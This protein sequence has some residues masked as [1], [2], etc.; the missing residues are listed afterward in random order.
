MGG[1][2]V[3]R[4][5]G[6]KRIDPAGIVMSAPM[7]GFHPG[8]VPDAIMHTVAKIVASLGDRRRPAWK[9]SEK[10]GQLPEGRALLLTHDPVRYADEIW[11][12][13]HRREL[14]MGPGSWGW[15][16]RSY[17]AKRVIER[18]GFL[19]AIETPVYIVAT[20][21]DKLVEYGAIE[22]AVRRLPRGELFL[23]GEECH[24]EIFREIDAIR[25][26]AIE[27]IDGFLTL[28]A[29]KGGKDRA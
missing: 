24:H 26:L 28:I 29:E 10:P 22:R 7:L 12:R 21:H 23:F 2:V 5:V 11:W 8:W 6:E 18:P 19:E 15:V 3:L 13:E 14:V 16:E 1:L 17:A 4:A 20:D 9:W 27:G 25:D